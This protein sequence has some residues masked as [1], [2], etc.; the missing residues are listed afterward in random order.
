MIEK[1]RDARL[2]SP[3]ALIA[4][5]LGQTIELRRTNPATGRPEYTPGRILSG[6]DGGVVFQS[7]EGI[8]ALR[9]SGL[10]ETF[11]FSLAPQ[12][13]SAK[14]T[15]SVL[16]NARQ[17]LDVTVTLSYLAR[18]FDW[19][20][21][22]VA[23][24]ARDGKTIDLGSWITLA[25]GNG[26]GFVSA[27][28]N[29]VAGRIKRDTGAVQPIDLAQPIIAR[30]W[31]SQSTSD[32]PPPEGEYAIVQ[33]RA[34]SIAPP[35]SMDSAI[36]VTGSRVMQEQLGDLKLYHVPERTDI[37][38][39]QSKQVRL[40][41]R[42]KIPVERIYR[43]VIDEDRSGEFQPA[44]VV[45]RTKNDAAHHLGLPLPSGRVAVLQGGSVRPLLL[46]N[47][48]I[49]DTAVQEKI[50][51]QLGDAPDVEIRHTLESREITER[52]VTTLPLVPGAIWLRRVSPS[53]IH[54]VEVSNAGA[55]AVT[56]ELKTMV[57]PSDQ[58]VRA[59]HPV[60]N[61]DG[62]P[63]FRL[64]L[65]PHGSRVIRYVTQPRVSGSDS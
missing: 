32:L 65:L 59:D 41:D 13:L 5:S 1:N 6:A 30:C 18:G 7:A 8:E 45:L 3:S 15:L 48:G 62:F 60:S 2:L 39:R 43:A 40:L 19:S 12:G 56:L 16:T 17:A 14:P 24:L 51:L 33:S 63:V 58:I 57:E 27:N 21:D 38:S 54:R 28:A 4:A 37:N 42:T 49:R 47:A 35:A 61:E 64:R 9:C 31:P 55:T 23:T 10:P 11:S 46:G 29:V 22:Y 25:N 44:Q 20:A 34:M 26:T 52:S 53:L 50:E 36:V